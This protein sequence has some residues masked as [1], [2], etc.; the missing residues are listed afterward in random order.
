[1]PVYAITDDLTADEAMVEASRPSEAL[2]IYLGDR[3]TVSDALTVPD[4]LRRRE[5][6]VRTILAESE[7]EP[8]PFTPEPTIGDVLPDGAMQDEGDSLVLPDDDDEEDEDDEEEDEDDEI[9]AGR[10]LGQ[11]LPSESPDVDEEGLTA[12]ETAQ[13]EPLFVRMSKLA[14]ENAP[15]AADG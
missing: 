14:R 9:E 6:G 1:M 8:G 7:Q 10:R 13:A 2:N 11:A 5:R 15:E 12:G 3:F 4:A